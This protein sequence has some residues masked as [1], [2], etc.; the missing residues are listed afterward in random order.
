MSITIKEHS[1]L[2]IVLI[3]LF[4]AFLYNATAISQT[5]F[6]PGTQIDPMDFYY[7]QGRR[8]IKLPQKGKIT[9]FY[10][11]FSQSNTN[12]EIEYFSSIENCFNS[13]Q[14]S[15]YTVVLDSTNVTNN[16]TKNCVY[17]SN[18]EIVQYFWEINLRNSNSDD[19]NNFILLINQFGLIKYR[20]ILENTKKFTSILENLG[21]DFALP[22]N[23]NLYNILNSNNIYNYLNNNKLNFSEIKKSKKPSLFVFYTSLCLP[24][25]EHLLLKEIYDFYL[26]NNDCNFSIY[27]IFNNIN[28]QKNELLKQ[29]I[30]DFNISSE[31]IY[32]AKNITPELGL[33]FLK[34]NPFLVYFSKDGEM[35]KTRIGN[36][37]TK[38]ALERFLMSLDCDQVF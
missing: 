35:I 34:A 33:F 11:P 3:L 1:N 2:F 5:K 38:P 26:I 15:I 32:D 7:F 16:Y 18:T 36:S 8:Y 17:S 28:Q 22:K 23:I 14:I 20:G 27:Y 12:N 10:F 37:L 25:G 19:Y 9:L 4:S 30:V 6:E 31:N 21:L 29:L 24:C 13:D